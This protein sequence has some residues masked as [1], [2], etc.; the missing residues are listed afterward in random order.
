LRQFVEIP[1]AAGLA[2]KTIINI[3]TV[4]KFVVASAVERKAIKFILVLGTMSSFNC[5]WSSMAGRDGAANR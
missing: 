3:V 1:A 5:P 4:V 2:P